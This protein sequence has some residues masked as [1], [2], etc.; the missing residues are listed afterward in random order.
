MCSKSKR[1][2]INLIN[3]PLR[4][5]PCRRTIH[6]RSD[7]NVTNKVLE[8]RGKK[9]CMYLKKAQRNRYFESGGVYILLE[10]ELELEVKL[11]LKWHGKFMCFNLYSL[12]NYQIKL[13]VTT[14]VG[15]RPRQMS[16]QDRE[17]WH[18]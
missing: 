6:N 4:Q 11:G 1:K 14:R 16:V 7:T 12:V 10:L 3:F 15:A 2:T 13:G 17:L 9:V 18:L 5:K 8:N